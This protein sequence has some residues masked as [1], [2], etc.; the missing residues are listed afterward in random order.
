M[1]RRWRE[2]MRQCRHAVRMRHSLRWRLTKALL[3]CIVLAFAGWKGY[4]SWQLTRERTGFWDTS[5]Q[6][7]ATQIV[8]SMPDNLALLAQ[9]AK[10]SRRSDGQDDHKMSFQ[11]WAGGRNVVHSPSAPAAAMKPDFADGFATRNIGGETWRVYSV[12]D[13]KRGIIVQV[14]RTQDM[15]AQEFSGWVRVG[16]IAALQIF[17]LFALVAWLVIGRSLRPV[18]ALRRTLLA[19]QPLDLTPLPV[20][21][22]PTELQP[23]VEA[24]NGQLARV[25]EALQHERRF[26]ADA[27][28]ELRTPLAVLIAHADLALRATT[29]D[30]KNTALQRLSAGVQ[31]SARL[32]EQLLDLARLDTATDSPERVPVDLSELVVLLVRDFETLARERRQRITLNAEPAIVMGDIDQLGILLRNLLDNAVRHAGEGGLVA[33]SCRQATRDEGPVIE[34]QV[35]D[36]GPGVPEPDRGR[37]FDRFYRVP[38]HRGN[39]NGSGIGLSLVARAA[40]SHAARIEVGDGLDGRGLSV[41]VIFPRV[42][43]Q[44]SSDA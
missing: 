3:L 32:S 18:T 41:T 44:Q 15:M 38:S 12:A 10:P 7:I 37:I 36:N 40:R 35:A 6:E 9:T 13:R 42:Q 21:P 5:L 2:G 11:I 23:L 29:I 20:T 19:R 26:I 27:A 25:D 30:E 1:R 17:V 14:G 24:F 43:A 34:F 28:H 39:G 31:R 16:L 33:V 4:Q 22:I 8:Q